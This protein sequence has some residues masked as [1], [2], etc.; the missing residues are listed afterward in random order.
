MIRHHPNEISLSEFAAGTLDEGRSLVIACHVVKCSACRMFLS[1]LDHI[2]G[3]LLER[4]TPIA[5]TEGAKARAL[6]RL[7]ELGDDIKPESGGDPLSRYQLGRWRWIGPG[8]QRRIVELPPDN[9]ARVFLL[10]AAPGTTMPEHRHVGTELTLVLSG[11]FVHQGG[12]FAPGDIDDADDSVEHDPV[13]DPGEE[14]VCLVAMQGHLRLNSLLGRLI[15]PF[16]RL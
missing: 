13:V 9:G 10:K 4:T 3:Q 5:M 12:R 8:I 6:S 1:G 11:A 14:C 15:E 16:V 2:G 7:P